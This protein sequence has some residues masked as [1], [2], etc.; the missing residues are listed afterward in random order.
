MTTTATRL[1]PAAADLR[2]ITRHWADLRDMLDTPTIATWPPS[3]LAN[4][5]AALDD[6]AREQHRADQAAEYAERTATAMGERPVP[7]K[8]AVLD[9]IQALDA[10]LLHCADQIA[11]TIQRPAIT[12]RRSAGPGDTIGQALRLAAAQDEA[13]SRRWRWNGPGRDGGT[14]AKWLCARVLDAD[15]PFAPLSPGDRDRIAAVA[16]AA[17]T[18]VESTLGLARREDPIT[19]RCPCTGPMVLRQGGALD[20]EVECQLCGMRWVGAAMATLVQQDAA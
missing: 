15:G 5:L 7:L 4:Y 14:A 8:L 1:S 16:Q 2:T 9:T 11:S 6:D 20:P 10:Q 13:D 12:V 19:R 18:R 3:G 17:R